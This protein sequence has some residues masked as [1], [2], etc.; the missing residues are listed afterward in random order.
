MFDKN[1]NFKLL[2]KRIEVTM[3]GQFVSVMFIA[4]LIVLIV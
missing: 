1:K 2:D 3:G 4:H